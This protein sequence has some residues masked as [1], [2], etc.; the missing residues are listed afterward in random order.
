MQEVGWGSLKATM[1]ELRG[2]GVN[3]PCS[4][5]GDVFRLLVSR[6]GLGTP[7]RY[8]AMSMPELG[9]MEINQPIHQILK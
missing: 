2:D 4:S 3:L 1:R 9:K 5:M 7:R 6:Q 8:E